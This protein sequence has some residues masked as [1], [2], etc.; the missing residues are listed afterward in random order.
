MKILVTGGAGFIGSHTVDLL[1]AKGH[2]VVI[3]DNLSNGK[4]ENVN[5]NAKFYKADIKSQELMEIFEKEKPEAVIHLAAHIN[6]RKSMENPDHD[7]K[8]NVFGTLNVLECCKKAGVKKIIYSSTAAVYGEPSYL[9][10]DEKHPV[11]PT[12][13]YGLSKSIAENYLKL[14]SRLYGI[15]YVIHR[16][17]NVYGPR[18]DPL[19]EAGVISIF[20]DKLLSDHDAEIFGSGKQ[21]RDYVFVEDVARANALALEAENGTYNIGTGKPTSVNEL[22]DII[23]KRANSSSSAVHKEPKNEVMHLHFSTVLAKEKMKWSPETSLE[24]GIEK[25]L[26]HF[27]KKN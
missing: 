23:K 14:Y 20:T 2:E 11:N 5:K 21:T 10:V 26:K 22:F 27:M 16:Y 17:A 9:P 4:V 19:G 13:P 3:V 24:N 8:E 7:M 1:I 25:T 6:L 12:S 15:N 18:Q